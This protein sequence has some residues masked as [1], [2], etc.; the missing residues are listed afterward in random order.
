MFF[1][2]FYNSK[3]W[4]SPAFG[5][6][7]KDSEVITNLPQK[8]PA[9]ATPTTAGDGYRQPE[10]LCSEAFCLRFH[11]GSKEPK[12]ERSFA[13]AQDFASLEHHK[14]VKKKKKGKNK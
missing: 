7:T 5:R 3:T 13:P 8:L 9:S 2:L 14:T 11:N 4:S 6:E 1:F 12:P 10:I